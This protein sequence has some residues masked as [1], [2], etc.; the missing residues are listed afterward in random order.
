MS[1]MLYIGEKLRDARKREMLTQQELAARSGVGI[2][3]IV[4]IERNQTEP[5][6]RNIRKLADALDVSP[7]ELMDD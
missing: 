1:E 7:R 3:T 4:R 6:G 5:Q 2:T